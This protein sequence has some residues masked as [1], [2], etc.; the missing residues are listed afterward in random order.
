MIVDC[1]IKIKS[2]LDHLQVAT[3]ESGPNNIC[4]LP[5][6]GYDTMEFD[7]S[8]IRIQAL[9]DAGNSAMRD[10]LTAKNRRLD[11]TSYID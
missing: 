3:I 5:A 11:P 4:R 10:F 1:E 2:P 6:Q 8:A 7:M 9:I